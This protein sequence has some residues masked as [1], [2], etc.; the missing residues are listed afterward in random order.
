METR[1]VHPAKQ[2][3]MVKDIGPF[4][5]VYDH[6]NMNDMTADDFIILIDLLNE[7]ING[8]YNQY[9]TIQLKT[10]TVNIL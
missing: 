3:E 10:W 9:E 8:K 6:M 4:E 1:Y 7:W 5:C 2:W